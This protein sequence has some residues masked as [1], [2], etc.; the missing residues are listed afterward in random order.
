MLQSSER[1][2]ITSKRSN[3]K[4]N[5]E[6]LVSYKYGNCFT[7]SFFYNIKKIS[8]HGKIKCKFRQTFVGFHWFLPTLNLVV[9]YERVKYKGEPSQ[10]RK[11]AFTYLKEKKMRK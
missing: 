11:A 7:L 9:V 4:I 1:S 6:S 10:K 2:I 5:V 3:P 8:E